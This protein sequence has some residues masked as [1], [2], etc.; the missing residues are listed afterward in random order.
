MTSLESTVM[1]FNMLMR[2]FKEPPRV[3]IYDNACNLWKCVIHKVEYTK[4]LI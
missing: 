4:L 2:K 3:I 1:V